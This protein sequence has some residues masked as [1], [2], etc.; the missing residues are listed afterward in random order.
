MASHLTEKERHSSMK[1]TRGGPIFNNPRKT[2][3]ALIKNYV[4][5]HFGKLTTRSFRNAREGGIESPRV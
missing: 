1:G 4:E 3:R 2:L 5:D